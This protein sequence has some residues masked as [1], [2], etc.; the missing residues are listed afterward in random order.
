VLWLADEIDGISEEL[1][2]NGK[3]RDR[4]PDTGSG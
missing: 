2:Q 1:K 3:I 4:T